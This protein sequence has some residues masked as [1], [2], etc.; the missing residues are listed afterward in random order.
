MITNPD[1]PDEIHVF[2]GRVI[3]RNRK[4]PHHQETLDAGQ[5]RHSNP[6][7]RLKSL[8]SRPEAFLVR[9][10]E[11][12]SDG[13]T[14][15]GG[16]E[17]GTS[18]PDL[19]YGA[20][21]TPSLLPGWRFG[22]G[23]TVVKSTSAGRPGFGE[24][25]FTILS[26]TADTQVAF[27][28]DT[29]DRPTAAEVSIYQSF[30]TEPGHDYQVEFEMG[31]LFYRDAPLEITASVHGG[32]GRQGK[33]LARHVERRSRKSGNGYNPPARFRFTAASTVTTLVF[34]ETSESSR[35]ADPVLDNVSVSKFDGD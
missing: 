27:L 8:A 35:S 17:S 5:S 7:G 24:E 13:L 15:N 29:W 30:Q 14:I 32:A 3:A 4:P 11:A 1:I 33:A 26:S 6:A 20:F 31:G 9:L 23:I 21:A 10:R 25:R 34:T 16:F 18:P 22:A 2:K 28:A 12:A 19:S